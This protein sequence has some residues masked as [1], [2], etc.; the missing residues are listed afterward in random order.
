MANSRYSV[1]DATLHVHE[2]GT[3][4]PLLFI[5]GFPLD[6]TMWRH[7]IRALASEFRAIAPDL[8]GFGQ[9]S[10]TEGTVT[11]EQ[12]ADDLG[13]LLDE[14]QVTEKAVICG[15]S[16]GGY[17]AWQFWRKYSKRVRAMVL[18]DTRAVADTDDA[19]AARL[20]MA[21]AVLQKGPAI[22]A[23]AMMPKLLA[24]GTSR[25]SP[26]IVDE[27]RQ[28]ILNTPAAGIAAAQRGMAARQNVEAMLPTISAPC[29]VLVG[30]HD[31]ISPV[32]EMRQ[33][34]SSIPAAKFTIVPDA[35]HMAPLENPDFVNKE[36]RTF[37][38]ELS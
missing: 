4:I 31:V 32:D 16:L 3:G 23:E 27:M 5:H 2:E 34:A 20:K 37:L 33:I 26:E 36:L 11:M 38:R 9:S 8:C 19:S 25:R 17:I 1:G 21:E 35:G 14:M 28:T 24:A 13:A 6:H 12:F 7:Q 29:L 30:E 18:C 22:V 10:V 15:F